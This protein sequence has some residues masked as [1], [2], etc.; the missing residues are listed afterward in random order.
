MAVV[1]FC[2]KLP[3]S[4]ANPKLDEVIGQKRRIIVFNKADLTPEHIQQHVSDFY[5]QRGQPCLFT[6]GQ[7]SASVKRLLPL[8][9][10]Q[11]NRKFTTIP[12]S[13]L[14]IVSQTHAAHQH[15]HDLRGLQRDM[16]LCSA[17]LSCRGM[18]LSTDVLVVGYPN[19]GSVLYTRASPLLCA[20]LPFP[21]VLT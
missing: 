18:A 13:Q 21:L 5:E 15:E 3:F 17:S 1:M 2:F 9:E 14:R 10:A 6:H 16:C 12:L 7:H 20:V 19:V 4:S 11:C 8:I